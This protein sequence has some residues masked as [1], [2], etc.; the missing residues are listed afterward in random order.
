MKARPYRGCLAVTDF[1]RRLRNDLPRRFEVR[2]E[3]PPGRQAQVDFAEFTV[4]FT[5]EPGIR[6]RVQQIQAWPASSAINA[7]MQYLY[8][9]MNLPYMVM[10]AGSSFADTVLTIS[11]GFAVAAR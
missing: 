10:K 4:G 5:D 9:S 7:S 3:T 8:A 1:L 2:F 6:R 11:D